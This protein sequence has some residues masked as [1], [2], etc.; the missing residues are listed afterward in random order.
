MQKGPAAT[1]N[2]TAAPHAAGRGVAVGPSSPACGYVS[3]RIESGLSQGDLDTQAHNSQ[4]EEA[5]QVCTD[6]GR[7]S[8]V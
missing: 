7:S 1:A 8:K 4:R 6:D 3:K 5:A 2:A